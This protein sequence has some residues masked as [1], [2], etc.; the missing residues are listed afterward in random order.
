MLLQKKKQKETENLVESIIKDKNPFKSAGLE[1]I[2]IEDEL[3]D[4]NDPQSIVE[5]SKKITNE[6][7]PNSLIDLGIATPPNG[8]D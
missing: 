4:S 8:D 1:D 5:T 3:V 6:I 7:T 2:W